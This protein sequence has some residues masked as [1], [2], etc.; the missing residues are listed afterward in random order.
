MNILLTNDDGYQSP[1]I[2]RIKERLRLEGHEVYLVAPKYNN[3]GVSMAISLK[4]GV[5]V[6]AVDQYEYIVEG[7]PADC[8]IFAVEKVIKNRAID[9]VISGVNNGANIG[10]ETFYSGTVGAARLAHVNGM[11]ALAISYNHFTPSDAEVELCVNYVVDLVNKYYENQD[12]MPYY[13]NVNIPYP[14]KENLDYEFSKLGKRTYEN[15]LQD[16]PECPEH[17]IKFYYSGTVIEDDEPG[18]DSHTIA[19]GKIAIT[20]L[21]GLQMV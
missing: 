15:Q 10:Y 8:I 16:H 4:N 9:L 20:K 21:N 18:T 7:T 1:S 13:L 2:H 12:F 19:N 17:I 11:N 6:E 3:S 5:T 14:V